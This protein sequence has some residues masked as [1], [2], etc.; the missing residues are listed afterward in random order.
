MAD[1]EACK[2]GAIA[3]LEDLGYIVHLELQPH[4]PRP[5][6]RRPALDVV[7]DRTVVSQ[8]RDDAVKPE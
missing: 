7:R 1:R 4:Q 2:R 8:D 6:R 5:G 3:V